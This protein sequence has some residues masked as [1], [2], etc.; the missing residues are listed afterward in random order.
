MNADDKT[1]VEP[2]ISVICDPSKLDDRGCN[3]APDWVIEV[4]SPG[5]KRIDYGIKLFKYRSSGVREYWI[6]NPLTQ[7][8][9][10]YD[11]EGEELS[12][13][14]TFDDD[15]PGCIYDGLIINIST[16]LK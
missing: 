2:D 1:Y 14:Y 8:V 13:Q 6:V 15:I 9:N 7:T 5:T 11:L 12:D 4:A 16:L 10:V 3:G